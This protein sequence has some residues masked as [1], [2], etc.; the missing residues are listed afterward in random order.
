MTA[1]SN[2]TGESLAHEFHEQDH[3]KDVS[4]AHDNLCIVEMF[5]HIWKAVKT[6]LTSEELGKAREHLS[7]YAECQERLIMESA[8][9][10][11]TTAHIKSVGDTDDGYTQYQN[12][13]D[14]STKFLEHLNT[15][16]GIKHTYVLK[17]R[18]ELLL[19][20]DRDISTKFLPRQVKI[21]DEVSVPA[22][23]IE[24]TAEQVFA[25]VHT[26]LSPEEG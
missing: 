5:Q 19:D 17:L 20:R 25:K 21:V 23:A 15:K 11:L 7:N 13:K 3:D 1:A 26:L 12:A 8:Q 6:N 24:K 10:L 22:V 9:A 16:T 18:D 4:L 14:F 2:S